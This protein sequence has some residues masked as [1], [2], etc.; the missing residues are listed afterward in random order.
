[1]TAILV[2]ACSVIFSRAD[3]YTLPSLLPN[4]NRLKLATPQSALR[5]AAP[6]RGAPL[7][8]KDFGLAWP[9]CPQQKHTREAL[10][11]PVCSA[12]QKSPVRTFFDK[13]HP[14]SI[15][16][17]SKCCFAPKVVDVSRLL[18]GG[19]LYLRRPFLAAARSRRGS[20]MPPACHSLPRRR[21]ATPQAPPLLSYPRPAAHV[22]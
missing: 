14:P 17:L 12:C 19:L 4:G 10:Q 8:G 7:R 1:M 9:R 15:L 2:S 22:I 11:L 6:L 21:C 13:L 5:L 16:I 3:F 18:D 20:D